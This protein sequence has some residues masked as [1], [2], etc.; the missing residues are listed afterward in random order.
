MAESPFE[1]ESPTQSLYSSHPD[2][3]RNG[4]I[5]PGKY[6]P[7]ES[8]EQHYLNLCSS[9]QWIGAQADTKELVFN[10]NA[11]VGLTNLIIRQ[12]SKVSKLLPLFILKCQASTNTRCYV[13][14]Q[15]FRVRRGWL[16]PLSL[17]LDRKDM[18]GCCLHHPYQCLTCIHV[19]FIV[20]LP[21]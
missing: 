3:H 13:R 17:Y 4:H 20:C 16:H 10:L 19:C 1:L 5:W 8:T 7:F 14:I 9:Q 15:R 21:H 18:R 2:H 11:S 6:L 12:Y